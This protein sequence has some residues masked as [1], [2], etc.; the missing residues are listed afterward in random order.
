MIEKL[1]FPVV[2]L[3]SPGMVE[4][5][6]NKDELGICSRTAL[7]KGYFKGLLLIDSNGMQFKVISANK[8]GYIGPFF[9]FNIF[10]NQKLKVELKFSD[11]IDKIS[12]DEFRKRVV[13]TFNQDRFFWESGG[14]FNELISLVNKTPTIS[15]IIKML[16]KRL[17][18][19]YK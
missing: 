13:K 19:V 10:L 14:D 8:I 17:F 15:E 16:E 11:K 5:F 2:S 1:K 7:K 18:H 3:Q 9:G 6:R 12:L 4:V